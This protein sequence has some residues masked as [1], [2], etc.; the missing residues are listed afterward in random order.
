MSLRK[1]ASRLER[2]GR[3][4]LPVAAAFLAALLWGT[5]TAGQEVRTYHNNNARSGY[6]KETILTTA[7]VN[8][9]T[10]GKLFTIAVDGK[11]DAQPLYLSSVAT[12][13][14]THNLL[15]VATEHDS[16]YV[17]DADTGAPVWHIRTLKSGETPSDDRGCDQVSPEI[18]IT[19]TPV[20]ARPV[21]SNGVIYAVAMSKDGTGTYH[22]RLHAIDAATGNELLNGPVEIN[23]KYPG[24]GDNSSGG[25]VI[26]DPSQYKERSGLLLL[27]GI[28]YLAWASHCDYRPYTGWIMGYK[29]STLAQT[30]V[31]NVTPNG[32]DGAF[33]GSG[34]GLAADNT[35]NIYALTSNGVF[36]SSL[37]SAGF[38]SGGDYGNAFLKISAKAGLAVADYFEMYNQQ[39]EN[40]SDI[41]LGSGGA[42]VLPD[43]KDSSGNTWQLAAGAGKDGNLYL[44]NRAAMGK[45]HPNG[46]NIYQEL[47]GVLPGGIWSAPAY[48]FG[49]LYF[50]PVGSPLLAFQFKNARLLPAAVA[51]TPNTFGYPGATPSISSNG[52]TN[53]IVW[54]AE[55]SFPAVLHAYNAFNLKE[56]YNSNQAAN[57]RDHFGSGNKF[58]TPTIAN[59]KV[60]VGTTNGV[61]VFGLLK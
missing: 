45:F 6:M 50:G 5:V 8:F 53:A 20:I 44:V 9:T 12:T 58:I 56:L 31:L 19:S 1:F 30:A 29:A 17:F 51:Q 38:P 23:A 48:A 24:S 60:Y 41:D 34:A 54:A 21:G 15:I 33:W 11:V 49:R 25:Y 40:N 36:D 42:V 43:M 3:P 61:G 16:M 4:L 22:Q 55:N 57:N 14:G 52:T 37:N 32:N 10:F 47:P 59:G 26:F 39:A 13:T 2:S 35:F 18:G 27:N 46:N 7:N 28:V